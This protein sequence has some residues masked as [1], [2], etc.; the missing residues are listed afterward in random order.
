MTEFLAHLFDTSD[1]P[2]RWHCGNWSD[3]HGWLHILSDLGV[4]SAYF[5]IPCILGFFIA[6]RRDLPFRTIFLLF[7]AFI[8]ACGTTHLM[9]AAIFWWPAYRLAGVIKLLTAAVSWGTV[10]ALVPVV[11]KVLSMRSPEELEREIALRTKAEQ[12]LQHANAELERRVQE[13]TTE[14]QS[15]N[16]ALYRER[17]WFST[18]L[19][20]IGDAV[21]AT[22]TDGRVTMLNSVAESLAGWSRREAVGQPL[23]A[24][25]RIINEK[26]RQPVEDP[27]SQAIQTGII[28]GLANHT[29]LISKDGTERPIADSAA[30]IKDDQGAIFGAVL[31]FRDVSEQ[32]KAEASLE[33]SRRLYLDLYESAPDLMCSL[34]AGSGDVAQCNQTMADTLGCAKEEIVGHSIHQ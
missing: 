5:A 24:I 9:E 11:P 7:G 10:V 21:I 32:R 19:A 1:F 22:D 3:F 28:I 33:E 13:R 23:T 6:R 27:A 20:S 12:E 4:W 14:L 34:D 29:L 18:T 2:A 26:T 8:L 30:P 16:A 17:E 25:F 31:V 15:A